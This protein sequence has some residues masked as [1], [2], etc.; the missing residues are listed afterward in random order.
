MEAPSSLALN[1]LS[2]MATKPFRIR[3]VTTFVTLDSLDFDNG[4]L[5]KKIDQCASNLRGIESRLVKDGYEVQTVRIA[6]NPFGEWL[7]PNVRG[8]MSDDEKSIII[9]RL[10]NLNALLGQHD[11]NFC[12]LGPSMLPEHTTSICPLIVSISPGR[13]ACSANIDA[14]DVQAS[15][16]AAKC[17]KLI[18]SSEQMKTF[19]NSSAVIG[20]GAHLAGGLGNFRFCAASYVKSGVPFFPAAKAPSKGVGKHNS[21][22]FAL[23]LENGGYVAHLLQEAKS[24]VNVQRVF[25]DGWKRELLPIQQLCLDYVDTINNHEFPIE[26]LGIDTSLNP[27]LDNSGSVAC[28]I[29][30]LGEVRGRFGQGSLAA[31]AIITTSLQSIPD[32]ITTGYCGLMLPVLEDQRLAELGMLTQSND[33]IDIQKLLC[34]S[35]VC[36]VGVDTVPIPGDSPDENLSSLMLDVAG[37]AGRWNKQLS[38]RVFPVPNGKSG[39][40]TQFDSPYMCNSCIFRID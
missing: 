30:S 25:A 17:L 29:E 13:F 39:E 28:A 40:M 23:G 33:R 14:C 37:L 35:S 2:I 1:I 16:A 34:I 9:S 20:D 6:T 27:S 26:Y 10:Q 7:V 32:I 8:G 3:T 15:M 36:G 12:S 22:R 38:C 11:I 19:V 5:E 21:I 24:I 18:S 4:I 31:A